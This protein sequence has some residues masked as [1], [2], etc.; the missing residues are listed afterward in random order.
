MITIQTI[1]KICLKKEEN[2]NHKMTNSQFIFKTISLIVFVSLISYTNG[3]NTDDQSTLNKKGKWAEKNLLLKA[4]SVIGLVC[5]LSMAAIYTVIAY[6]RKSLIAKQNGNEEDKEKGTIGN[7]LDELFKSTAGEEEKYKDGKRKSL[8]TEEESSRA[9]KVH[10]FLLRAMTLPQSVIQTVGKIQTIQITEPSANLVDSI[11]SKNQANSSS[12]SSPTGNSNLISTTCT[13]TQV[14]RPANF[15][16]RPTAVK[17]PS[18]TYLK[19]SPSPTGQKS[20]PQAH[21]NTIDLVAE[22]QE[23]SSTQKS[24]DTPSTSRDQDN[25]STDNQSSKLD[26]DDSYGEFKLGKLQFCLKYNYEKHAIT[27]SMIK[28]MNLPGKNT[29]NTYVKL[30][31]LPEKKHKVKTR[32]IRKNQN[33]CYQ[34]DFTF[35]NIQPQQLDNLALHFMIMSFDR[36]SRDEVLGEVLHPCSD[37]F[38]T[39]EKQISLTLDICPKGLLSKAQGRGEILLS[40]CYHPSSALL[41]LVVLKAKNL[42]KVNITGLPDPYVKINL[43]VNNKRVAKKKT[44]SKKRTLNPI[45]NEIFSFDLSNYMPNDA[46]DSNDDSADLSVWNDIKL[47]LI[48]IDYD[49]ITRNENIGCLTLCINDE[50]ANVR[51]H[52]KDMLN[53]SRKQIASWHKLREI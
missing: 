28:C 39:I 10:G 26:F 32:T 2:L 52:I 40:L 19:K 50:D 13:P 30:Q 51:K 41:S 46:S 44:H 34:E 31:L 7:T 49:R 9:A 16:G 5:M 42:Q 22:K 48:V 47:E 8:P 43:Y 29:M 6:R 15:K 24:D 23:T 4:G 38:D 33:P 1:T 3:L 25:I 53:Q 35:F 17:S 21:P 45:Y 18:S 20:P 12:T 36:Y 37:Q 11:V 27:V 14:E